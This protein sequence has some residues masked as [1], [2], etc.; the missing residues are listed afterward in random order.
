MKWEVDL[1]PYQMEFFE[2]QDRYPCMI[3]AWGTGKTMTAILK[4]MDLSI[5]YP[6]NL[7]LI[8]RQDFTDLRDSTM[9]DFEDYTG[10]NVPS[11]K[12]VV[13]SNGSRI[14]FRHGSE[15]KKLQ[16][17]NLGWFYIEQAEEFETDENFQLLRGRLRREGVP[18][19]GFLIANAKG[20]NWLWRMWK[21][22]PQEDFH[23]VEAQTF[24]NP[25]LP[26]KFVADLARMKEQSPSHYRRFVLN[27]HEDVDTDDKCIPYELLMSAVDRKVLPFHQSSRRYTA[28]RI[29]WRPPVGYLG[30]QG[31]LGQR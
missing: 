27:S 6:G 10:I 30:W 7:G 22:D 23:L 21:K 9:N 11:N 4:A 17:I 5:R 19:Q 28:K 29:Q 14:M 8:C 15:L 31:R 18:H 24:D 3:S 1:L 2:S 13:L 26:E 12:D 16:N 25:H 20:H